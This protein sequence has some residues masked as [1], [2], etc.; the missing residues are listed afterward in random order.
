MRPMQKKTGKVLKKIKAKKSSW[1]VYSYKD[2]GKNYF[3]NRLVRLNGYII[4]EN[5]GF[6]TMQ[7]AIHNI[8]VI[9]KSI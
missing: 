7:G 8:A 5:K 1:E 2:K 3:G 6:Q 4:L 9:Q